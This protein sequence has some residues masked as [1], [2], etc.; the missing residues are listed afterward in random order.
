MQ[1]YQK[2]FGVRRFS[3]RK[4]KYVPFLSCKKEKITE[5]KEASRGLLRPLNKHCIVKRRNCQ[6]M[7]EQNS[8][9]IVSDFTG[10]LLICQKNSDICKAKIRF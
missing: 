10:C 2:Y 9:N 4:V 3:K 7:H 8:S 1:I 6:S 5:K